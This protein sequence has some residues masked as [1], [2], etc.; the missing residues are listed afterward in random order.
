MDLVVLGDRYVTC[1]AACSVLRICAKVYAPQINAT[2]TAMR[3]INHNA[4][5]KGCGILLHLLI[6]EAI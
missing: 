5:K 3:T 1:L 6:V 4:I 2:R